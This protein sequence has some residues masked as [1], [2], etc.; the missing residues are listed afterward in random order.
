MLMNHKKCLPDTVLMETEY[1]DTAWIVKD[2]LPPGL[3]LIA[4]K[5]KAGKS[6]LC[7]DMGAHIAEGIPFLGK[8]SQKGEVIFIS[9]EDD[10]RII[11][12]NRGN[13][14]NTK[15]I[16]NLYY[17]TD[18]PKGAQAITEL[19]GIIQSNPELKLIVIDI[20]GCIIQYVSGDQSNRY[21]FISHTLDQ[22]KQ[23][24]KGTDVS[25]MMVHHVGKKDYALSQ[26]KILGSTAYQGKVD[27]FWI[28]EDKGTAYS[29]IINGKVIS[30][31]QELS[32][33]RGKD[34]PFS[35]ILP[36]DPTPTE[37]NK[38]L[39][40]IN[41]S[42]EALGPKQ[43]S[44]IMDKDTNIIGQMLY[45]LINQGL[46]A[47]LGKGQYVSLDFEQRTKYYSPFNN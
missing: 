37:I 15:G 47:K 1:K 41:S 38:L 20:I 34:Q 6:F 25:I 45:R 2:L 3:S 10:E 14:W 7:L 26:D 46:I 18:F 43:I 31:Q 21:D 17:L 23:I 33:T 35:V 13:L 28:L 27:T 19:N 36:P 29:L 22:F 9:L 39:E 11:R 24:L 40:F 32:L 12:R 42:N 30:G 4:G 5:P 44:K 8:A 16:P